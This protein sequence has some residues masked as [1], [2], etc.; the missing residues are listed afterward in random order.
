MGCVSDSNFAYL[1]DF[2]YNAH[3]A[4]DA[5]GNAKHTNNIRQCDFY[6]VTNWVVLREI[7]LNLIKLNSPNN[8]R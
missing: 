6:N 7:K 4:Q 2:A 1:A 3:T 8:N 5:R